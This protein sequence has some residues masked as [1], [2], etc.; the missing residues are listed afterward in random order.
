M[1]QATWSQPELKTCFHCGGALDSLSRCHSCGATSEAKG[2]FPKRILA[3]NPHSRI[4]LAEDATG[5][6]IALKELIFALVPRVEALD[7]F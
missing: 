6:Q 5:H 1:S 7:A 3:E 4:Y 2:Y